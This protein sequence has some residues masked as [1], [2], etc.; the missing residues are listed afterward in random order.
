M[1]F[2]IAL[3]V[4]LYCGVG[5]ILYS[6]ISEFSI[7]SDLLLTYQL[8]ELLAFEPVRARTAIGHFL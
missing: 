6:R 7:L 3:L 5:F 1:R 2:G 8:Q 4:D